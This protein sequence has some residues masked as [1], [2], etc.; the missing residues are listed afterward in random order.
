[1]SKTAKSK[2]EGLTVRRSIE[3]TALSVEEGADSTLA[4]SNAEMLLDH[5]RSVMWD[6]MREAGQ[7]DDPKY[8]RI[9][10]DDLATLEF[11]ITV[12]QGLYSGA[13]AQA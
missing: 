8:A 7:S 5:V 10:Y 3:G 11:L 4:L 6:R 1:M 12:A 2:P 9:Y 13:G